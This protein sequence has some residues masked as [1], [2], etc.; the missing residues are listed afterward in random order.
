[1]PPPLR[2]ADDGSFEW[3]DSPAGSRVHVELDQAD[4]GRFHVSRLTIEG[5]PLAAEHL[6]AVPVGR[7][8]AAANAMF[9]G[10][11]ASFRKPAKIS[12]RLR[13]NAGRGYSDSFYDAVAGGYQALVAS[14]SRPISDLAESNDVPLTT[15]QRWVR[16][17]RR[18]GKLPP[19][20]SGKAG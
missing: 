17:A 14:S 19:G 1:M 7:I 13:Q 5:S 20:R 15:A 12:D 16:E 18:R 2:P 6:R 9:H 10:E 4:D 8:E 3:L 11:P